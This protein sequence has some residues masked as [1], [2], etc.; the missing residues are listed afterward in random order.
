MNNKKYK[1]SK[2]H[3]DNILNKRE[4]KAHSGR[5]YRIKNTK[6]MTEVKYEEF[7]K[8]LNERVPFRTN[9]EDVN[10]ALYIHNGTVI[11]KSKHNDGEDRYWIFVEESDE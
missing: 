5:A 7:T 2:R 10:N 4:V 8:H 3:L 11:G 6:K 1:L 9:S